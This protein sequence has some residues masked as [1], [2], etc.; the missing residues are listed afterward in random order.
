MKKEKTFCQLLTPFEET[1]GVGWEEYPRPGMK[2]ESYM[3]LCGKW[4]LYLKEQGGCETA[5]LGEITV[6]FPPESRMSGI[7]RSKDKGDK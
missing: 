4:E 6:P 3:S 2:R 5:F 7:F 1:E